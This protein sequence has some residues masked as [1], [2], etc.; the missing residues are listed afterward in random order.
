MGKRPIREA[1][2]SC[3][4]ALTLTS[5]AQA[6]LAGWWKFDE[7]SGAVAE[8]SVAGNDGVLHGNPQWITG[9]VDNALKLD[10]SG[11][12]VDLP[13]GSLM[14]SLSDTTIA[15]WTNFSGTGGAWQRLIDF[16]TGTAN[17]IY[18]CPQDGGGLMHAAIT[19]NTGVWTDVTVSRGAL[20][21]GWHHVALVINGQTKNLKIL[22]DGEVVADTSTLYT[23]QDLGNTTQNYVGRSQYEDPYYNGVVDDLRIYNEALSQPEILRVMRGETFPAVKPSPSNEAVDVPREPVL[24]WTPGKFANTHDVYFGTAFEDV[25]AATTA[26]PLGVLAG[27]GQ[28][29]NSFSPGRLQFG[30]TYFWRVD[31]VNAPPDN[32]IFQ[33]RVWSFTVE[34]YSYPIAG[35][36]ATASSFNKDMGPEKAANGAGLDAADQHSTVSADGWLTAKGAAGPA[37]IQFAFDG[38]HKL[39]KMLVWNSNQALENILGLGARDVTIEYSTDGETWTSFGDFEF[40]Q[41]T[42]SAD[43]AANTTIEFAGLAAR[44][45][46]LTIHSNWGGLM[47]QYGLSEVRFYS[48][49]V[50]AREPQPAANATDVNPQ[51]RFA[52]RAG[53]E[54]ASHKILLSD[55]R[56][57]VADGSAPAATVSVSQYEASL[58]L[59]STYFWKVMEVNDAEAISSWESPV[60][61][62]STAGFVAVDDFEAYTDVEG[63]RVYES[64]I[65]GWDNPANGST[66]GYNQAP[67]AEQTVVHSDAQ[68]M[69]LFYENTGGATYSEAKRTFAAPQDWTAHG[70]TTLVLFF[71]GQMTNSPA[72]VY[73]KINDTKILYNNAAASTAFPLWKQW[74]IPLASAGVSLKSVRSLSVGVEG[75]GAGT[76]FVDD[77][78]LYGAAPEVVG[79]TDPGAA[80]LVALYAMDDSV[81][82]SS[83]RN[84]HGTLNSPAGYNAGYSGKA[85]G[86]NGSSTYVDLPIGPLMPTLSSVTV[87]SHVNFNGGSGSWQRIFDFGT[88]TTNYMFLCPRQGTAGAMRFAIRTPTVAEK[89]VDAPKA[90]PTGWHHVAVTIDSATMTMTLYLDGDPVGKAATTLLPK[91]LGVTTQ[92]WLG[93]SQ[94]V[95]DAYFS[96]MLDEF[97]IYNRALSAAEVR[98]LAGDR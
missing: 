80:G 13:I 77:I 56:Q 3:L 67:F 29:T 42:A 2:L 79:A 81:Q 66:V 21:T 41:A 26:N 60:W 35:V 6:G 27:A 84:Y 83:G 94:Y 61:S 43:Y 17:Y 18:L 4:L 19:A 85:L 39:D 88:G 78:R 33:G 69:P 72:A 64:W 51:V 38:V 10:G 11:D 52:W 96:G 91:D 98:Y 92:N 15:V 12:Y 58:M 8:D 89:T 23:L 49:P 73:V 24:S 47:P 90:M 37:W 86:F 95:A 20:P 48:I 71:R 14:A 25:N 74:N 55:D 31:E 16:G 50:V 53:R 75:P 62:F 97:R 68:S 40:A 1:L 57:A 7:V 76:L 70:F 63:R 22:L 93:R 5:A 87:A 59:D 34:P 32:T 28:D 65:D 82:D 45:I 46:K 44:L 9:Q 54:A 36:T 30:R